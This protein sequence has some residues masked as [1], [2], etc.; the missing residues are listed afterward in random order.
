MSYLPRGNGRRSGGSGRSPGG[1]GDPSD[2]SAGRP[3]GSP[4]PGD[5]DGDGA[6]EEPQPRDTPDEDPTEAVPTVPPPAQERPRQRPSADDPFTIL[7]G[8]GQSSARAGAGAES[9]PVSRRQHRQ[10]AVAAER[11]PFVL[12]ALATVVPGSGLTL[13]RRR[14]LGIPLLVVFGIGV[15]L[16]LIYLIRRGVVASALDL[17]ARP[18]LLRG[19]VLVIVGAA[20]IWIVQIVLTAVL[21][22]PRPTRR[23]VGW[24]LTAFTTAMCLLVVTPVAIGITNIN[25]HTEAADKIFVPRPTSA[26]GGSTLTRDPEAPDPWAGVDRVN[27]LLLGSDAAD[28]REG[29]RTDSMIVASIDAQGGDTVLFSIPRNLENAPIPED[30]PL[31]Q[32]WPNGFDCGAECL[33]NGIWTEAEQAAQNDP[34]AW[35]GID[36]PGLT[37][38]QD[39]LSE[40]LGLPIDQT[41]IINLDGFQGLVDAMGGVD[42]NVQERV[43]IGGQ[44]QQVEGGT[45]LLPGSESGWIEVGEQRLNGRQTLWYARSRATSDDFSRMRRQRCVVGA[46]V[47]QVDPATM[48]ANYTAIAEVAGDNVRVDIAQEDL[49]AWVDLVLRVQGGTI[50]SLPFTAQNIQ[51]WDP[52][53]EGIRAEVQDAIAP[54]EPEPEVTASPSAPQGEDAEEP[55]A[56]DDPTSE[57]TTEDTEDAEPTEDES[58]TPTGIPTDDDLADIDAVC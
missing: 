55:E 22:R 51:V 54:P 34:A 7:R 23:N 43:P 50:R 3:S 28:A 33:V 53:Y 58:V 29:T 32:V 1:P 31:S 35:E 40:I 9:A 18:G 20:L 36:N 26:G 14:A 27:V 4:D 8:R 39:V 52:D 38:T 42:I 45:T 2:P 10:R 41:V 5:D 49:P 13:A 19:L 47:D 57:E 15:L 21:S 46:L 17:A 12:T 6:R 16:G 37:A 25:A 30:S 56:A 48:L 44:L 11:R 24:A